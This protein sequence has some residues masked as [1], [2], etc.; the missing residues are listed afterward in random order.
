MSASAFK[1]RLLP[2]LLA[3]AGRLPIPADL[4][5]QADP[6]RALQALSLTGQALRFERPTTPP[7]FA[8]EP[9][10]EDTR[11]ILPDTLRRPLLRL[12]A[13]KPTTEHPAQALSRAF[14]K[15]R[16]RPHPFD[17][18]RLDAFVR[19]HAERLGATAQAWA[20]RQTEAAAPAHYFDR[21]QLDETTWTQ[22][23][24]ARRAAW[25]EELRRKDAAAARALLETAWPQESADLRHRLLQAMRTGLSP[26]D[27]PFLA[28]L[29][30]DRAPR[31]RA[32]AL[33][34]L[35][36]LG[37]GG[38]NPA[39]RACL[40]RITK[41]QTGL[42]RKRPVLTL[43][44]PANV[45]EADAPRWLRE[46]FAEV[47]FGELAA[48]LSLTESE[49]IEASTKQA[50]LMLGL[51][52]L[53]IADARLDL[54]EAIVPAHVPAA[55]ESMHLSGLDDLGLM[56]T[57]ERQ[58][59]AEILARPYG[60]NP[61]ANYYAWAWLHRL[62]DAPAPATLMDTV[63]RTGWLDELSGIERQGQMWLELLAA[64]CPPAQRPTLRQRMDYFDAAISTTA[65]QLLDILDA[66]ELHAK[67]K[68]RPNA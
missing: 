27:Q 7:Q 4:L 29:D 39:L 14:D 6:N 25:L 40:E 61:P 20:H 12:F 53:A 16:L 32:L 1:A 35:S 48:A 42:L 46:H 57:A 60:R 41:G 63:C 50:T 21:E 3:G 54:L 68:V 8:I 66:L 64:L 45:K 13:A 5:N 51:A 17:L 49:L 52:F 28:T 38:E 9:A 19:T 34:L 33:Q 31:V 37:L 55:W 15:L 36:R 58:R 24:P 23:T 65:V 67:E 10:L 59:W 44:L 26:A 2:S 43:D 22:A 30:K 11:T 62:L 56:S 47:G 18:P